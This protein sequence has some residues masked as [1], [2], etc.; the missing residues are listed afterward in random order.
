MKKLKTIGL[1]RLVSFFKSIFVVASIFLSLNLAFAETTVIPQVES[2]PSTK[3]IVEFYKEGN[4]AQVE[5]CFVNGMNSKNDA[6]FEI[7]YVCGST[8]V[9]MGSRDPQINQ[10]WLDDHFS[11][12]LNTA[13]FQ[14]AQEEVALI[15]E[16]SKN[17][18]DGQK[19]QK[20]S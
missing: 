1:H 3:Q 4:K 15:R 6:D 16:V 5:Q 14:K 17:S 8:M 20:V 11:H 2:M 13:D 7:A 10:S 19:S 18:Q 12:I 9:L